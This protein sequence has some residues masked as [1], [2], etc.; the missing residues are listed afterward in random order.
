MKED[1]M[2]YEMIYEYERGRMT[3]EESIV[4]ESLI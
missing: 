2:I 1:Y 4:H 3:H